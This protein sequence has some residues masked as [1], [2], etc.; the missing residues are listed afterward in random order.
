MAGASFR[1]ND[2]GGVNARGK[3]GLPEGKSCTVPLKRGTGGTHWSP[4]ILGTWHLVGGKTCPY[5][6]GQVTNI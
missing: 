3:P 6:E 2:W 5:R 1:E 4:S